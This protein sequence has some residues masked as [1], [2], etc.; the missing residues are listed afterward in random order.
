M[1]I[2]LIK[3]FPP[4]ATYIF[5]FGF[6]HL[7]I[8]IGNNFPARAHRQGVTME[9]AYQLRGHRQP[10]V[11]FAQPWQWQ[12]KKMGAT[13]VAARGAWG[14]GDKRKKKEC[15]IVATTQGGTATMLG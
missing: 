1:Y 13:G 11:V 14:R 15:K 2:Q 7:R 6:A 3:D 5:P 9:S 4:S 8:T 10:Q 12:P